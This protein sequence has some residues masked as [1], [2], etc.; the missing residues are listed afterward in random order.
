MPCSP[1][2]RVV[3]ASPVTSG[4]V[5][6][7]GTSTEQEMVYSRKFRSRMVAKMLPPNGRSA[8]MVSAEMGVPQ[9]TLS[10]WLREAD[11][12]DGMAPSTKRWTAAEKLRV[13]LKASQL[14]DTE[15]GELLRAEGLHE[16][17]LNGWRLD[18]EKALGEGP[19]KRRSSP[20]GR[21][22][23]QLEREIE[24]KDKAL[25]EVG[26]LLVLK[27]KAAAIWGDEDERTPEKS[28]S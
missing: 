4:E 9:P 25:A 1:C 23:R 14:K 28:E 24:R 22:I 27:K 3:V 7:Q 19:K 10:R 15:L 12:V 13:V 18:V 21:R 17:T 5:G 11:R 26:A 20:E 6:T 8:G 16:A 2:V